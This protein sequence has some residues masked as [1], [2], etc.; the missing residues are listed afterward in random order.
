M[1][2]DP[3]CRLVGKT[4]LVVGEFRMWTRGARAGKAF[5]AFS[6][7]YLQKSGQRALALRL[8]SI[9]RIC[10]INIHKRTL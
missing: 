10:V 2:S 5:R 9:F 4:C 8:L 3:Q 1:P 7:I 6:S